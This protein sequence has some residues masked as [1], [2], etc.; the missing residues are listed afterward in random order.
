MEGPRSAANRLIDSLLVSPALLTRYWRAVP[1]FVVFCIVAGMWA[2]RYPNIT[3]L[4]L[5]FVRWERPP[6]SARRRKRSRDP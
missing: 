6:S 5:P 1:L 4:W 3:K 2:E